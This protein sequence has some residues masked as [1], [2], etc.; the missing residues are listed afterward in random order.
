MRLSLMLLAPGPVD[1]A[2]RTADTLFGTF[3]GPVMVLILL[4]ALVALLRTLGAT[5][6]LVKSPLVMFS[7]KVT[8]FRSTPTM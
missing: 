6:G 2:G 4:L 7:W 5:V 3:M 1:Q 8:I